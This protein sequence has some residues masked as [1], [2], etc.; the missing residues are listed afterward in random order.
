MEFGSQSGCW[1]WEER[2][3]MTPLQPHSVDRQ[4]GR[5]GEVHGA[6]AQPDLL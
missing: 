3:T 6:G 5:G 4:Q 1:G 2:S